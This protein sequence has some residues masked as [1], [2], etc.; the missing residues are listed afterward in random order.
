MD[1]LSKKLTWGYRRALRE[2][3]GRLGRIRLAARLPKGPCQEFYSPASFWRPKRKPGS[4]WTEHAPFA[5]WMVD[6]LR[7]RTIV[8]LGTHNGYSLLCFC[9]AI[10]EIG[11]S[12]AR[13]YGIDT[14]QGDQ[15]AGFYGENVMQ[16]LESYHQPRYGEFST[17]VKSTF[18][19]ALPTF[20]DG[21]IDLLHID[22]R[23]FYE[24]VKHDFESWRP[25]LSNRA[26]VL[27][28][29]TRVLDR[30]FG[31]LRLWSEVSQDTPSFEFAHCCGLG[32]LGLGSNLP[33]RLSK[34]LALPKDGEV[35][36]NVRTVYEELGATC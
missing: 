24:D 19:D 27:F 22:G 20:E 10:K 16:R 1:K 23:H 25:K 12:S 14:W 18:D 26:V 28:H 2:V 21:S 36:R 35:A 29:D 3:R 9:Q 17:L 5:F 13:A 8:E 31:V 30:N 34:L 6:T 4:A 7:P 33:P 32:V 11:Y 15:Q